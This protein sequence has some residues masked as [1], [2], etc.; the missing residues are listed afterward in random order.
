MTAQELYK[1]GMDEMANLDIEALKR[2]LVRCNDGAIEDVLNT[3]VSANYQWT[4]AMV[5]S[6]QP[7]QIVELGGAMGVW[8]ICVLHTLASE[9][10]LYSITLAEQG[11]EFSF[12]PHAYNNFTPI[13]GDDLEMS[14]W[15]GIDLSK[16]DVWYIDTGIADDHF[17][18]QLQKEMDLYSPY[19]KKGA[20]ILFDDIHKSEGMSAVWEEIK[21]GKW[22]S[23]DM[24]DATD[25][26]HWTG[27][28]ITIKL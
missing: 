26:L 12:M 20:I 5:K 6:L 3:N 17:A 18:H 24:Y 11:L 9:N 10:H 19:F 8:A 7:K 28:G 13:V 25:P 4:A 23:Y 15:K 16:T 22:G 21:T 2:D 27:W 14:N 1:L